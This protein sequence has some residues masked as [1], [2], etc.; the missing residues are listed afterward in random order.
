[1]EKNS[2]PVSRMP[3]GAKAL[4]TI[5]VMVAATALI[6][7]QLPK[8]ALSTDLSRIG[9]GVPALVVARDI[10]YVA[11]GEV[12]DLMND[13]RP[14]Y[15]DRLEFLVAHLGR[16]EGQ[17]FARRLGARDGT[18][19]L[20]AGDGSRLATLHAPKTEAEIRGALE[21]FNIH[22]MH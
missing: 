22:Y 16:P 8:G 6:Y 12:M 20:F 1:M 21:A 2:R 3:R 11:G 5:A 10:N 18:V 9:Q 13:M 14:H 15:G 19:V 4:I 17:D 7:T